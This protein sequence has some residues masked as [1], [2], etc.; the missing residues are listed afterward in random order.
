MQKPQYFKYL[1]QYIVYL[2]FTKSWKGPRLDSV[3]DVAL[4]KALV[5]VLQSM[6]PGRSIVGSKS[7]VINHFAHDPALEGETEGI[8]VS[9]VVE[10]Q[11]PLC[12]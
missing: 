9:E 10:K 12:S 4:Q 3:M 7:A 11:G 8:I 2:R 5:L 1:S 6:C